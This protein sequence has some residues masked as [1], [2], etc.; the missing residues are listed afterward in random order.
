MRKSFTALSSVCLVI[1]L[2]GS[3]A[4]QGVDDRPVPT[5][6][7]GT[8]DEAI[9]T[10][11]GLGFRPAESGTSINSDL[12]TGRW[13]TAGTDLLIAAVTEIPNGALLTQVAFYVQDTDASAEF[14]GRL[15]RNWV[16]SLTGG[17]PGSDCPVVV[18]TVGTPGSTVLFSTPNPLNLFVSYR[19][20][21]DGSGGV[22]SVS[23]TLDGSWGGNTTGDIRLRQV[24]L[25][26]KRQVTPAPG[27]ATFADV[28][29]GSPF[30]RFV[31]ALVA[32][33]IT[34]GCGGGLYC[35]DQ[36]VTRG[37]MAVFLSAALGLH[38]PAM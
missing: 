32:S 34:G 33:G 4:A 28:P 11:S 35:P 36:P 30:H 13:I 18:Q 38:W 19:F 15:C 14:T 16:D 2:G 7:F 23:Y 29:V 9:S 6:S 3:P 21:V 10:V 5:S 22:D 31:E 25:L 17:S 12:S 26:W 27:S 8:S 24:R 20:N 1:V 37:Q